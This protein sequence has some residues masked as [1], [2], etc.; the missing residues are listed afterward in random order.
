LYEIVIDQLLDQKLAQLGT[1]L[2]ADKEALDREESPQALA[3]Y[4][5]HTLG[6]TLAKIQG[7]DR[8]KQQVD[9][10][11][12]VL[13][14]L[15]EVSPTIE[16]ATI[17]EDAQRL[18]SV[19]RT[20]NTAPLPRPDT[21]LSISSLLTGTRLDPSLLSQLKKEILAA[22]QIDILCSFIKWSGI[23]VLEEELRMFTSNPNARLRIITTSYMGATDLKAVD[24][25]QSLPNTILKVSY[26]THRTRL[27]AKAYLFHRATG[28]G[29][30]YVGSSNLSHAAITDGLE[31]NI[32]ISEYET[33][34]LWLKLNA[35]FET[36]WNDAEFEQYSSA[37]QERLQYALQAERTGGDQSEPTFYF[38][39]RPY[40]YQQEIL[41]RLD[42]ER[43]LQNRHRHLVV[44]ATGTGKTIIAAFDYKN[45][46]RQAA[47]D[48][49][50]VL[51]IA[52]RE[53]I[54]KQSLATFRGVLKD[55]NFGELLTAGKQP[56]EWKHVFASIQ[57]YNS[58]KLWKLASE[59]FDYVV[60]DEFHHAAAPSYERLLNHVRP[61]VLLGL[62]ATPDR[63]D[64]LDVT[65]FFDG[66]ISAEI[67]LADA[68]N[69]KLLS[70][71]QYFGV[72]DS[73]DLND[74]QWQR[75]GYRIEDLNAAFTGNE[76]RAN[77]VLQK[78]QEK[79]LDI[80]QAR[81]LGFCASVAHAN[82]MADHFR[83]NGI[84]AEALS[85]ESNRDLRE[86]AQGRLRKREINF[87]FAVDI[88][89][90]GSDIPEIDTVFFLRPT[91]SLTVFLQQLG[92]GLRLSDG[93]DTLTVLDFIG[94]AHRKFRFDWRFRALLSDPS[95]PVLHQL[96]QNFPHLPAGCSI[97]LEKVARQHVL[98]N[99]TQ[100]VRQNRPALV[101]EIASLANS[102]KRPP[103]MPEFLEQ[104][105]LSTDD[106]YRR[107]VSWARLC[108]E[109]KV[110][111]DFVEP[112]EEVITKGLRR[113]QHIDSPHFI[114][115][116]LRAIKEPND[117]AGDWDE[118]TKRNIVMLMF[119]LWGRSALPKS[120]KEGFQRL[121]SNPQL[122]R[123]LQDLVQYK[124]SCVDSVAPPISLPFLC[125][126]EL[127]A[128]YT[129]DE[130]LAGLGYWSLREQK[131]MREGILHLRSI[132][133]DAFFVTLNKAEKDY[134]PTTMYEDYAINENL[135]HWQSQSTTSEE[136]PTGR[137]YIEHAKSGHSILLFAREHKAING[138]SA[139]YSFLGPMVYESHK[140]SRPMSMLWRLTYPLSAKLLRRMARL[141]ID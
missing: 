91:E 93:K 56:T 2:V 43:Q 4:L 8:L 119:S 62:T 24:F 3:Q 30:A 72:T 92:R 75:G 81:G 125:P 61:K 34:H 82:F 90:E 39:L 111:S 123:E 40:S 84:P 109:A 48:N 37:Q 80:R 32:K 55:Q 106:I 120:V 74:L 13:C 60:V 88:Y 129:R 31:W 131:E 113:F 139:P 71:F 1:G 64:G 141:A 133:A 69:R 53:E 11:N 134:S 70:P 130:V 97:E 10:C 58:Q 36:Y 15:N 19:S 122:C 121:N 35:T 6:E 57:S 101:S 112:D 110:L 116:L 68:I 21:P 14:I 25:L 95:L 85:G 76:L 23:R 63:A 98:S 107:G 29:T 27:H 20:N 108:V 18:L 89:N 38:D 42:A 41:D 87:I 94:Q 128:S 22:D 12:R 17:A 49:P 136:S 26:D 73:V 77:L 102:L 50:S 104:L 124:L 96:Q 54:L 137:R 83:R 132:S 126:L 140:G 59:K 67:R 127:H 114:Q 117:A 115:R 65:K 33:S 66:H 28:F 52:H 5:Q 51:F 45:W 105:G 118:M 135:F 100:S 47:Q 7:T 44:A 16:R 79:L 9:I 46:K 78:A 103:S 99:I 86:S 138:L